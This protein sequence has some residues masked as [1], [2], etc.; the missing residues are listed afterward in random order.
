M[1]VPLK[2]TNRNAIRSNNLQFLGIYL[3]DCYSTYNKGTCTSMFIEALFTII[4]LWKQ[5]RC[6][7]TNEWIKK[8]WYLFTM[9]FYTG[10]KENEI[11]SFIGIWMEW[12]W[13]TSA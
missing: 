1:E 9:E 12:N 3:K 11:L 8:M 2:S 6:P 13:K 5:Q 4:K 10:T 7:T